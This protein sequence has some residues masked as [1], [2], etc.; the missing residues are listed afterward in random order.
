[1]QF[2]NLFVCSIIFL[3]IIFSNQYY[4]NLMTVNQIANFMEQ[5]CSWEADTYL[6]SQEIFHF[7]KTL[8]AHSS[9]CETQTLNPDLSE[10]N[11]VYVLTS[12]LILSSLIILALQS[13]FFP[14]GFWIK[15]LHAIPISHVCYMSSLTHP[16][17]VDYPNTNCLRVKIMQFIIVLV[18]DASCSI[19]SHM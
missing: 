8:K 6:S 9:A 18:S 13:D 10:D 11:T 1:M 2:V 3:C 7:M 12:C 4:S 16:L 15:I 5:S 17:S 19:L 14:S